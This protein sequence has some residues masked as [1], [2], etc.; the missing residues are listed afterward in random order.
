MLSFGFCSK[1]ARC[2]LSDAFFSLEDEAIALRKTLP[3]MWDRE[4]VGYGLV[5]A[6]EGNS[7]APF[8]ATSAAVKAALDC[9]TSSPEHNTPPRLIVAFP[10]VVTASPLFECRLG[11]NG[12]TELR[13]IDRGFFFYQRRIGKLPPT[14][15]AIVAEKG[16]GHYIDEC[17]TTCHSLMTIFGPAVNQLWEADKQG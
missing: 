11:D 16:L 9:F 1:D 8:A 12:E 13:E 17:T 3:W 5:Q 15:V 6:F 14:T 7:D 10:V 2:I 4:S